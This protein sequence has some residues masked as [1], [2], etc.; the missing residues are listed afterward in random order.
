[1]LQWYVC[2]MS[3]VITF[4]V[5]HLLYYSFSLYYKLGGHCLLKKP[6]NCWIMHIKIVM[7]V[8][9]QFD[10]YNRCRKCNIVVIMCHYYY[11]VGCQFSLDYFSTLL[12][13]R[14][15]DL[16]QYLLQLCQVSE[17]YTIRLCAIFICA[18]PS[19]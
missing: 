15:T 4:L 12:F 18:S 11:I 10:V 9:S 19:S 14:D 6:W 16:S 1:M 13:C 17:N 2:N 7:F 5:I 8:H 3:K